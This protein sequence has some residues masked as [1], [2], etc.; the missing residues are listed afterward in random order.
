MTVSLAVFKNIP[1]LLYITCHF[2][3]C[4]MLIEFSCWNSLET[5]F[6]AYSTLV[7]TG[8]RSSN[9]HVILVIL[10]Y[11]NFLRCSI[12]NQVISAV[13]VIELR[14]VFSTHKAS[15]TGCNQEKHRQV[16]FH[17][18][19]QL[20]WSAETWKFITGLS[21]ATKCCSLHAVCIIHP[22]KIALIKQFLRHVCSY[23]THTLIRHYV[24]VYV[25]SSFFV[26]YVLAI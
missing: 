14:R 16:R 17:I 13:P 25:C 9:H 11:R 5:K 15:A 10:M 19:S 6:I 22:H 1:V 21:F 18:G 4:A 8:I 7:Q 26:E 20:R 23:A 24:A 12:K 3:A 2:Y